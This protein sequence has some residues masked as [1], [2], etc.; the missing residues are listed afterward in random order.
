[1]GASRDPAAAI[2][3]IHSL[4]DQISGHERF[5]TNVQNAPRP[6]DYFIKEW[7][8][9]AAVA[10]IEA[11][12]AIGDSRAY[13]VLRTCLTGTNLELKKVAAEALGSIRAPECVDLLKKS[14]GDSS[15]A[16]RIAAAASL[17]KHGEQKWAGLIKG[18]DEDFKVLLNQESDHKDNVLQD[19]CNSL[20]IGDST[21]RC[22]A[23]E[24]LIRDWGGTGFRVLL[25][26]LKSRN[27]NIFDAGA[28]GFIST[29]ME[30]YGR[31]LEG[32]LGEGGKTAS[33]PA[34]QSTKDEAA[35]KL[36]ELSEA[37]KEA[38]ACMTDVIR[39]SQIQ[40]DTYNYFDHRTVRAI[41]F[42]R[43]YGDSGSIPA[44]D[45]LLI[46]AADKRE[47]EG[48]KRTYFQ[49][50]DYGGWIDNDSSVK[51]VQYAIAEIKARD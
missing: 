50:R 8:W 41:N 4:S 31:K 44:L 34:A 32:Q 28:W 47:K 20:D 16:V 37:V 11:L 12:G 49:A 13:D 30:D 21:G 15:P 5:R 17:S 27:E 38:A 26:A 9:D 40:N 45:T 25:L 43:K 6:L 42:L 36:K 51:T 23:V 10:M 14:L 39:E 22:N 33:D 46:K 18:N 3:L 2:P 29:P 19:L 24:N 48:F 1:L 35:L 7:N